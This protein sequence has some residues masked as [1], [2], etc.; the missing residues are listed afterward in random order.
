MSTLPARQDAIDKLFNDFEENGHKDESLDEMFEAIEEVVYMALLEKLGYS[1]SSDE[2]KK[3]VRLKMS[4]F[5]LNM[6][7]NSPA[8]V[9]A[10][11]MLHSIGA[12]SFEKAASYLEQLYAMR[13]KAFSEIQRKH[14][15]NPREKDPLSKILAK[16]VSRTPDI[17]AVEA[18]EQ[19]E[20]GLYDDVVEYFDEHIIEYTSPDGRICSVNKSAIPARLSRLRKK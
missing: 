7:F 13:S 16:L 17:S 9:H 3:L 4:E 8:I 14:A 20:S 1:N 11:N 2:Q 5:M 15:Q 10:E 18:I 19:L 6:D 12:G